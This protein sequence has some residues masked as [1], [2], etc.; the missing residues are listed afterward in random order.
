MR[1]LSRHILALIVQYLIGLTTSR[2]MRE[3]MTDENSSFASFN[4]TEYEVSWDINT[5]G[6]SGL[7][8]LLP[9]SRLLIHR[10][11]L[12]RP[13]SDSEPFPL[14]LSPTTPHLSSNHLL[15][16]PSTPLSLSITRD[17]PPPNHPPHISVGKK[18]LQK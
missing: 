13:G 8:W 12:K 9:V 4:L 7:A 2:V 10:E 16:T 14:P 11:V 3:F 1:L 15:P 17:S 18:Q 6:R 5:G